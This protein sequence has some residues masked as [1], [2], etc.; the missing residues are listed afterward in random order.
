MM[1]SIRS[2]LLSLSAA[3]L[4]GAFLLTLI[5]NGAIRRVASVLCGLMLVLTAIDPLVHLDAEDLA[6]SI[7]DFEISAEQAR[8][9]VE[10]RNQELKAR[11]ISEKARTY[12]LDKAEN[13]G[14]AIDAEV[15]TAQSDEGLYFCS[16]TFFGRA[17]EEK[18]RAL[19]QYVEE[20][21]AV[22]KERQLWMQTNSK[23]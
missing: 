12:I 17:P 4:L 16:V 9:G 20:N 18:K 10:V 19:E 1:Q 14:L 2:Y 21:L 8:S 11:I 6:R 13:L 7:T 5:P 23:P 22:P 15:E 3:A